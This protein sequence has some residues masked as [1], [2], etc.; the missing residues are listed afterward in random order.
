MHRENYWSVGYYHFIYS[1]Y[2]HFM[3]MAG[4]RPDSAKPRH[5]QYMLIPGRAS[6]AGCARGGAF[7]LAAKAREEHEGTCSAVKRLG[8]TLFQS[9]VFIPG[10]NY[11]VTKQIPMPFWVAGSWSIPASVSSVT[12]IGE[13]KK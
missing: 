11:Y 3:S 12:K 6:T 10:N 5:S 8:T 13:V 9:L 7:V 4:E 2:L 1:F